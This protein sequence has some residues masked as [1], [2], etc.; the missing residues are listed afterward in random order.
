MERQS[1][2]ITSTMNTIRRSFRKKYRE[3]PPTEFQDG[4]MQYQTR[5][6]IRESTRVKN[7][8]GQRKHRLQQIKK[9]QDIINATTKLAQICK[10]PGQQMEAQKALILSQAR[11][12]WLQSADTASCEMSRAATAEVGISDIRIPVVWRPRHL[13][14]DVGDD[15]QF[16]MFA[17]ISCQDQ[18]YDTALVYPIDRQSTD[19]SFSDVIT[20][21]M[22]PPDFCVKI[23]L[24]SCYLNPELSAS[25]ALV[26][27]IKSKLKGSQL[28]GLTLPD[29]TEIAVSNL[30]LSHASDEIQCFPLEARVTEKKEKPTLFGQI[31]CR[32]AVRPYIASQ[33]VRRGLLSISWPESDIVVTN[34]Y[35]ELKAWSLRLWTSQAEYRNA[36]APWKT[37]RLDNESVVREQQGLKFSIDNENEEHA[38]FICT[39]D[40]DQD[41]WVSALL[42]QTEAYQA[43][44]NAATSKM[45]IFGPD[46][47]FSLTTKRMNKKTNSKLLLMYNTI[48]GVNIKYDVL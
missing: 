40:E 47:T 19:I 24:Y 30:Q 41:S 33:C 26:N 46:P 21:S 3:L 25:K 10:N 32:L 36:V 29:F 5:S 7:G 17:L 23:S 8:A 9:E 28:K 6:R 4:M 2:T 31:C 20:F 1:S 35:A 44:K 14:Q 38:D 42:Q 12:A 45:E 18:I 34:C 11:L 37:V 15:R 27:L 22:L 13:L 39:D 16:A 48:S 43:W